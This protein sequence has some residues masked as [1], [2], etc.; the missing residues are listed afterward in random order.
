M[1]AVILSGGYPPSKDLLEKELSDSSCLICADS[2]GNCLFEYGIAPDYLIGDFDSINKEALQFFKGLK[3]NI[4]T[5]PVNK[6]YTDSEICL[7]KAL[8]MGMDEVVFLGCTGNRLDHF[9]SNL[10]LLL[11]ALKNGIKASIKDDK[12]E[13]ILAD[14]SLQIGGHGGKLFSLYAYS[15]FV[16]NLTLTGAKYPLTD[17]YLKKGDP[18]VTSNEF[19]NN[20]VKINLSSGLLLIIFSQD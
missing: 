19:L 10:G 17:Y 14:K 11:I 13:I 6:D 8:N 16:E 4:E 1:K 9:L 5:Y 7:S 3:I 15:D 18:L 12:N 2:G 20:I